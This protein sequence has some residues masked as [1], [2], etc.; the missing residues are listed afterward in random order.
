MLISDMTMPELTGDRLAAQ[1]K[2]LRPDLPVILLTGYSEKIQGQTGKDLGV[3][4][5]LFKPVD[6]VE[7]AA[8]IRT[9]LES[10]S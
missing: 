10:A 3:E 5:L 1:A 9:I 7:L 8:T 2:Q 6:K 4:G